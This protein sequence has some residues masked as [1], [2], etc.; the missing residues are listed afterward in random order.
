MSI[1]VELKGVD[2][3]GHISKVNV[4]PLGQLVTAP[5]AYD[6]ISSQVLSSTGTAY[7]FFKPKTRSKFVVSVILISA[8]RSVTTSTLVEVYE[9]S[10]EDSTVIDKSILNVD[11]L[12]SSYR[13][14]IGL[15]LLISEG[16]YLNVKTDDADVSLTIMGYYV[17]TFKGEGN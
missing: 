16:K 11:L 17:P 13:D 3:H 12:K 14:I 8:D 5:F 7:N 9:A 10:A 2:N 6:E 4:T 15:N 1:D